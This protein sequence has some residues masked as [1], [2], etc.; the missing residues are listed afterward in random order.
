MAGPSPSVYEI[1]P[2]LLR[3]SGQTGA[4]KDSGDHS[5]GGNGRHVDA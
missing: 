3:F 1:G 2:G 4:F 5:A